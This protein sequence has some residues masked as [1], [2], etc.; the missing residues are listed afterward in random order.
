MFRRLIGVA[1]S[2]CCLAF[3]VTV[4]AASSSVSVDE[5]A[6]IRGGGVCEK[7]SDLADS[8]C[9]T[10][11][12]W[13]IGWYK[14]CQ[15]NPTA[16]ACIPTG[17]V[18]GIKPVCTLHQPQCGGLATRGFTNNQCTGSSSGYES[19]TRTYSAATSSDGPMG[20]CP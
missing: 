8:E 16:S 2:L 19:C 14:K 6:A 13:G 5:L 11:E 7:P 9:T 4:C 12:P 17:A 20:T 10:C 18:N 1:G 15:N 3:G